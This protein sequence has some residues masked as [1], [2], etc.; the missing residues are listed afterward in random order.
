MT[1]Q[2][3]PIRNR[4]V[5][6][7]L[8]RFAA[9]F[10]VVQLHVATP[11]LWR[12]TDIHS[13][14]WLTCLF[15]DV[16]GRAGVPVFLMISGALLLGR[17]ESYGSFF[18]KRFTRVLI[19]L[20]FWT[21]VYEIKIVADH[22]FLHGGV[23]MDNIFSVLKN[24]LAGPVYDHLWF[25]YMIIGMYLVTPFLRR[26]I[27]V[28]RKNDLWYLLGLW[29]FSNI[30][31]PLF[32]NYSSF[33]LGLNIP[34]VTAYIGFYVLGY[35]LLRYTFSV[36]Q[37]KWTWAIFIAAYLLNVFTVWLDSR[38][39]GEM[40]PFY[41]SHHRPGIFIQSIAA[42][43]LLEY[44]A[45]KAFTRFSDKKFKFLA[46]LGGLTFGIYLVHPLI[47]ELFEGVTFGV[48]DPLIHAVPV[49]TIPFAAV[50]ITGISMGIISLMQKVPWL[51]KLV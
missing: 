47:I 45:K 6:F 22:H 44:Y 42:F 43:I 11:W 21:I 19:P 49:L 23:T 16:L 13:G 28:L 2:T 17:D 24:P 1:E 32:Y 3:V 4:A 34:V 8:V 20:I 35:Y 51:N 7:D 46:Y 37:I 48:Y 14:F 41:L 36:Q 15:F 5:H 10:A 40:R 38:L 27:P 29:I 30:L 50:I 33:Q 26:V 12:G 25:L 9:T 31:L 18:K 39:H